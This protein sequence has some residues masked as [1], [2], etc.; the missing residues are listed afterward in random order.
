MRVK[1]ARAPSN[2]RGRPL[3]IAGLA[4]VVI[5][6]VTVFAG[7]M[8]L[9]WPGGGA[10]AFMQRQSGALPW[11]GKQPLAA[12][13][14]G[15]GRHG[16]VDSLLVVSYHPRSHRAGILALPSTLWVTIPGFGDAPIG[17]AATE[18]GAKSLLVSTEGA[19]DT[20]IPYYAAIHQPD[21][22]QLIRSLGG[23]RTKRAPGLVGGRDPQTPRAEL[24][25]ALSFRRAIALPKNLLQLPT[26]LDNLA[27]HVT[28]NFP[29]DQALSLVRQLNLLPASRIHLGAVDTSSGAVAPYRVGVASVLLPHE[30]RLHRLAQ[31]VLGKIAPTRAAVTVVNG[32]G[33]NGQAGDLATWLTNVGVHVADVRSA[34]A[35]RQ[36]KTGVVVGS[37]S[38]KR[39]VMGAQQVANLLQVPLVQNRTG[40]GI[41]VITGND[42]RATPQQ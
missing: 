19:L 12:L 11:N 33:Q 24:G 41:H 42:Y 15:L 16:T 6:V 34:Q 25:L 18:G 30:L 22:K 20:P 14:I 4:V 28:T 39:T 21:F 31:R 29:Y 5:M 38:G 27:G 17:E 40:Q 7:A 10:A 8:S 9:L 37:R 2:R 32:T 3:A 35:L 23:L 36:V 26:I 1:T 13:L